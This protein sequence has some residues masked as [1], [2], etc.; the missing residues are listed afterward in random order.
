MRRRGGAGRPGAPPLPV[1][2]PGVWFLVVGV[3]LVVVVVVLIPEPGPLDDP[4]PAHQRSGLLV[5]AREARSVRGL[6]GR[7][8]G[9]GREVIVVV[10]DRKVPSSARYLDWV[11]ALPDDVSTVLVV[12]D[13]QRASPVEALIVDSD[14][15]LARAVGMRE[16]VDG[17][18]PVGY[19][20]ID[21]Q[22][23]LRYATL[24]PGYL[25]HPV[26]VSTMAGAVS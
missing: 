17:R 11:E 25:S 8:P 21:G 23:R 9:L 3:L 7:I 12:P 20:V 1:W 22:A 10:F 5:P 24:D 14:G 4:D 18:Y 19:A 13:R 16:P 2:A 6:H 26:G 15:S